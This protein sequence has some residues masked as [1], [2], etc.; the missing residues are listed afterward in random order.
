MFVMLVRLIGWIIFA[1]FL[2]SLVRVV[3]WILRPLRV[4]RPGNAGG[5]RFDRS[6]GRDGIG[7]QAREEAGR[8]PAFEAREDQLVDVSFDEVEVE[9]EDEHAPRAGEEKSRTG[10][11]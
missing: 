8:S 2:A 11:R 4:R 5:N 10:G 6:A 3:L 7:G 9:V 1:F